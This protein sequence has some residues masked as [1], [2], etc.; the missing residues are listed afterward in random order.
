[1]TRLTFGLYAN[2]WVKN[3]K[4]ENIFVFTWVYVRKTGKLLKKQVKLLPCVV[5]RAGRKERVSQTGLGAHTPSVL[6][7]QTCI[8]YL[9]KT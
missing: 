2:F 1:M 3:G 4:K 6:L 9:I 7:S 5:G 8:Y